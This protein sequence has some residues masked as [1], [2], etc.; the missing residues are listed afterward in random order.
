M[1]QVIDVFIE[2]LLGDPLRFQERD[3]ETQL[4]CVRRVRKTDCC[5][6]QMHKVLSGYQGYTLDSGLLYSC[7]PAQK[8]HEK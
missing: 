5:C 1:R 8:G 7:I 4:E 3:E 2:K 6:S